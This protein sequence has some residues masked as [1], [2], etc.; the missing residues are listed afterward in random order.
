MHLPKRSKWLPWQGQ[1]K[2]FSSEFHCRQGK[3]G[4]MEVT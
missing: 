3:E 1:S 2:V 4:E